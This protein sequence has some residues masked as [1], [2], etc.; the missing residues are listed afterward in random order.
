L[1]SASQAVWVLLRSNNDSSSNNDNVG[2]LFSKIS[3]AAAAIEQR[4]Q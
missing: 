4:Q 2:W 3:V 1:V